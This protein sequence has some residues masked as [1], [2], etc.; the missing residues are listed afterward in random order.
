MA[1][2]PVAGHFINVRIR[3]GGGRVGLWRCRGRGKSVGRLGG[4]CDCGRLRLRSLAIPLARV[5]DAN[6]WIEVALSLQVVFC[7]W[8][9]LR[10]N[11]NV[12]G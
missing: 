9:W 8:S 6:R 1:I 2:R 7:V 12:F 3:G 4:E 11:I 5:H 10:M